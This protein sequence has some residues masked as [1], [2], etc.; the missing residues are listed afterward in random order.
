MSH[1][2]RLQVGESIAETIGRT[3]LPGLR[4]LGDAKLSSSIFFAGVAN[5][6]RLYYILLENILFNKGFVND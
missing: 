1:L 5:L 6:C 4:I 3:I 2:E